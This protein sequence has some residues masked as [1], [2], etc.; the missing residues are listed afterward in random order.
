MKQD[1][2]IK[3]YIGDAFKIKMEGNVFVYLVPIV[4]IIEV[5]KK[6]YFEHKL[7]LKIITATDEK[8]KG[9]DFRVYYIFGVPKENIFLAPYIIL[10][11][12]KD[13]PSITKN[14]HEA[15]EYEKRIKSFFGLNPIGHPDVKQI[16]LHENW[17][18]DVFPLKKDFDW[19]TR[20][21][22]S[23]E[24]YKFQK[25]NGEGLYE[26][27]VGPVHAGIIEPGHFRFSMAGEEII[28]L[29]PRLGYTHKGSEKLFEILP[30][31]DKVRLSERISGDTSFTHSLAFCQ[32]IE[33]LS[34]IVVPERAKYLRVIFSEMERLANH[35]NDIGFIMLDAGYNFGGANCARLR[36]AIMQWNERLAGNR[37]L[38]GINV[39]GGVTRDITNETQAKLFTALKELHSDFNEVIEISKNS[40]SLLNRLSGT[41]RLNYQVAVDHGAVGVAGRAIGIEHDARLEYPYAAYKKITFNIALENDGDVRA[42]WSIRVKEFESSI[43]ILTQ[44]LNYISV[45]KNKELI[46]PTKIILKSNSLSVGIAE[47]WRGEIIYLVITDVAGNITRVDVRDPSVINW[48]LIEYA[49]KDNIIPDFPLINKSFN[50]S[51]SGNDL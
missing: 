8:S 7:P 9:E 34:G 51:Y 50:L 24:V 42:R 37:F 27:P 13:F 19:Q 10:K 36:E 16:L 32:A 5:C 15:S 1:E 20:P 38:R 23:H 6:L 43:T 39:I 30:M 11:D 21:A 22:E 14:I 29:E 41:G 17:P 18:S 45:H 47:G 44:A 49:I 4:D 26:I 31:E 46:T 12:R 2:I 25:A 40:S 3:K 48:T 35:L 28:S 33:N